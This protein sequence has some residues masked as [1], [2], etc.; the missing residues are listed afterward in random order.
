[1]PLGAVPHRQHVVGEPGRLVPGRGQRDGAADLVLVT[2]DLHPAQPVGVGPHRVVDADEI[3]VQPAAALG[4]EVRQQERHLVLRQRV[5]QRPGQLLPHAR[6]RRDVD[7]PRHELVP[8][9]GERA[10]GSPHRAEQRADEEQ[11]ARHLPSAQVA[12]G[13]RPPRVTGEAGPR[14]RD[15]AGGLGQD[16]LVDAGFGRGEAER[17][18]GVQPGQDLLE[19]LEGDRH[20]RMA[21]REVL[22]PVPPAA[23]ELPVVGLRLDQVVRDGQVDSGLAAR[24]RGQPV[25][26][27]GGRVG[28]PGVQHDHLRAVLPRLRDALG[29]RVEVVPALQ[30]GA[31]QVDDLGVRVVGAG[32]VDPHP[33]L[34]P[35]P[36]AAG[37]D[38]GVRVVAVDA[39]AGQ[40]P[41]GVPVLARPAD[42]HHDLVAASLGQ[43]GPDPGRQRV[44]DLVPADP[45]PPA[46]AARAGP[47]HRVQD[48][49]RV[50]DLV[51]RGRPL[52]AVAPARAGMLRVA[53]ELAHLPGV[54]VDVGQQ[55]A[56]GLAVEA[57]G[58]DEHVV[59]L[60]AG[61]PG[62]GGQLHPV[63]PPLLR[64]ERGQVHPARALVEGLP[65]R[66]GGG[67]RGRHP[68]RELVQAD[69][70]GGSHA[71]ASLWQ[72]S[73]TDCPACT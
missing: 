63:V 13:R 53:L 57:G 58:G 33:E 6:V 26:R 45:L 50:G 59:P 17:E 4:E 5:L 25:V 12:G 1:M 39:P 64:R 3:G 69:V 41:F 19:R 61:R 34:E 18:L 48:P 38:V 62:A 9:V 11:R 24:L 32:P 2:Q 73:G 55:P 31:D 15:D 21:G 60:L 71:A 28:Q 10:P 8:G 67:P 16:C 43:R 51:D 65:A 42:V 29:V 56:R 14:P 37:A 44:E 66:F 30:V 20:A 68:A 47:L 54:A 27:V 72:A 40:D 70:L 23:H 46:A 36:A 22:G 35:G 52:R 49:V 7:G